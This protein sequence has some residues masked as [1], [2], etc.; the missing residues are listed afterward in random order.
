MKSLHRND[1]RP[2]IYIVSTS[3]EQVELAVTATRNLEC[4]PLVYESLSDF[5]PYFIETAPGCV[6]LCIDQHDSH[7]SRMIDRILQRYASAQIILIAKDWALSGIINAIKQGAANVLAEPV[8]YSQMV[9]ALTESIACDRANRT[10]ISL[11]IPEAVAAQLDSDEAS[12][13]GL[14]I[15]G[16]TTKE[17]GSE[18][19]LSVRTIHYRKASMFRKLGVRNRSEAVEMVRTIRRG[20]P[21]FDFSNEIYPCAS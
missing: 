13:L 19:D 4:I 21:V 9:D 2:V 8:E 10:R 6:V 15:Q 20:K 16:R 1:L 5:Y 12:I 18:L 11:S 7:A 3:P 14:L 17:I